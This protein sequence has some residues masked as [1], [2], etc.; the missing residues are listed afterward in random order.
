MARVDV[1]ADMS[2]TIVDLLTP[3][4]APLPCDVRLSNTDE[5]RTFAPMA[6]TVTVFLYHMAINAEL[7]NNAPRMLGGGTVARPFLPL[8]LRYLI[9]PWATQPITGHRMLAHVMRR[10]SPFQTMERK[11][12]SGDSW[13]ED[14]TVQLLPQNLPVDEFHDIWDP[15]EIPYKLSIS[16]VAR[17]IGLDSA[18][19]DDF[20]IVTSASFIGPPPLT[21]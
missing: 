5:Y 7:R 2:Q 8:E 4:L 10:L 15:A 3:A 9:T 16:Y 6:P 21:A 17:V 19:A 12:L 11:Y 1:I 20:P 14:D 13:D 18:D